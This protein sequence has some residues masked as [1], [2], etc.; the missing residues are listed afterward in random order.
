[1]FE[2]NKI[3][4][5]LNNDKIDLSG[6]ISFVYNESEIAKMTISGMKTSSVN[7]HWVPFPDSHRI[8]VYIGEIINFLLVSIS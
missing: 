3:A 1:M 4:I 7:I 6:V 8:S 5:L 2:K